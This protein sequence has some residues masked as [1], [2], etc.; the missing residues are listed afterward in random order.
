MIIFVAEFEQSP[1][2]L[3][4]EIHKNNNSLNNKD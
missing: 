1:T 3:N 4:T 2:L